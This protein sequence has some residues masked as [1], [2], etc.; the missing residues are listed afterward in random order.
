MRCIMMFSLPK[1]IRNILKHSSGAVRQLPCESFG[2]Y[3][4]STAKNAFGLQD[5]GAQA[6]LPFLATSTWESHTHIHP[7]CLEACLLVNL[8]SDTLP[9]AEAEQM[10]KSL[11]DSVVHS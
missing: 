7:H 1:S 10:G 2:I 3:L 9:W 5:S 11:I 8:P 6:S 4:V